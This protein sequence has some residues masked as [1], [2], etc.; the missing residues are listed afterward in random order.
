MSYSELLGTWTIIAVRYGAEAGGEFGK[1]S[2]GNAICKED[3]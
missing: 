2:W 3:F 1:V